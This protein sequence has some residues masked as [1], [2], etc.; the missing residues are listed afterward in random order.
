MWGSLLA[1][2]PRDLTV[3]RF[4]V[5]DT[6]AVLGQRLRDGTISLVALA[7]LAGGALYW[8]RARYVGAI[9][10]RVAGDGETTRLKRLLSAVVRLAA[11][12]LPAALGSWLVYAALINTGALPRRLEPFAWAVLGGIAFVAFMGALA[13]ATLAPKWPARRIFGVA[14]RNARILKRMVTRAAAVL[15]SSKAVEALLQGISAGLSLSIVVRMSFALLFAW[16]VARSL[17]QLRD[18]Q[19]E[20]EA[21]ACLG[22]YVPVDGALLAPFRL[23]GWTLVVLIASSAVFGYVAF[24]SFLI[25]QAA[26]ALIVVTLAVMI[27]MLV[28][29]GS[30]ALL[31]GEGKVAMALQTNVGLRKRALEQAS[32]LSAGLFKLIILVVGAMLLLAPWG[33][34]SGDF[35]SSL[36]AAFFGFRVGDVTISLSSIIIAGVLF[37]LGLTATRALQGWLDDKLLPA[38]DLD[39]GLRNSLKTMAG[40]VGFVAAAALAIS[41]LGLSLERLTIVAGALSVGIGFGLQSI[42][43][44]FVSG[45]I[46]LWERPIRVGDLIVVGDGEGIVKRINVRSTEIETFDRATVIV[47]NSN[48]ISG[49]V[50]NRVRTDRTGR[51]IVSL[52]VPRTASPEAVRDVML[53]CAQLHPDVQRE[54]PPRVLFKKIGESTLEFDLICVVPEVDIAGRVQSDLHFAIYENFERDGIGQPER[55][56]SVKGLDRIEDTLEELVDTIEEAQDAQAQAAAQRRQKAEAARSA[57]RAGKGDAGSPPQDDKP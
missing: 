23:V 55:E 47:P 3:L 13:D 24:A 39:T 2:L 35:A 46:L 25:E 40:Y 14:D 20:E 53:M 56:V 5:D 44:N 31:V 34:E 49:V 27:L 32:V 42:V 8:V 33:V 10:A 17:N 51:V 7:L 21:N 43:S 19:A 16:V 18:T 57:R 36:R 15:A 54:P 4:L 29:E 41:S 11:G 48:L 37:A 9:M 30:Q 52:S 38:T 45:L 1:S 6:L 50:R 26:W 28:D 22:P 12:A